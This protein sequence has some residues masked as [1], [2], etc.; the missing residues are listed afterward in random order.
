M[1][2]EYLARAHHMTAKS[3]VGVDLSPYFL[4]GGC[5][6]IMIDMTETETETETET[7][8]DTETE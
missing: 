4:S 6:A 8:T 1:S 3:L 5:Q 2:T 7:D